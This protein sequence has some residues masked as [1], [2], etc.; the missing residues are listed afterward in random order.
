MN[1]IDRNFWVSLL[2]F[3]VTVGVIMLS[4]FLSYLLTIKLILG[5]LDY[6]SLRDVTFITYMLTIFSWPVVWFTIAMLFVYILWKTTRLYDGFMES[7][8][9]Y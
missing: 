2:K 4:G 7:I 5:E 1:T 9:D 6:S 8:Y 3:I